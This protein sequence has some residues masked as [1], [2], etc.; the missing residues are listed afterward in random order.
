CVVVEKLNE[1]VK[2]AYN[3][4]DEGDIILLSPACASW[5]Q[6]PDFESRGKD[7]KDIVEKLI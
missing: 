2:A 6:Y 7:F 4:S 5:D 3:L 1:A